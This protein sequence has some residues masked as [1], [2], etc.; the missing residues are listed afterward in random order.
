MVDPGGLE[1][2]RRMK[3]T[4]VQPPSWLDQRKILTE[5]SLS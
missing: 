5:F 3:F 2:G 1:R 4:Q